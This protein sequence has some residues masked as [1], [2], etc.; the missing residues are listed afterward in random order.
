MYKYLFTMSFLRFIQKYSEEG[1]NIWAITT[2][3]EPVNGII[4]IARFNS[5]GWTPQPMASFI[6]FMTTISTVEC[7]KTLCINTY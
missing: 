6:E 2:T 1:I 3:N 5:L 7:R 4:P